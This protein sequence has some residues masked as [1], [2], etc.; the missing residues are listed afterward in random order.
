MIFHIRGKISLK[1]TKFVV[2]DA[3]GIGYK[4]SVTGDTLQKI[5]LEGKEVFLWTYL[6]VRENAMDLYGFFD[7]ES[8]DFFEL[9]ITS[10]SGI[11]PKTALSILNVATVETLRNAI[12]SGDTS[13]LTKVS[14]IGK[15]NAEKI[16][17]ELRDKIGKFEGQSTVS[18]EVD[19]VEALKSLGYSQN[20]AREALKKID[21][22]ISGTG[23]KVKAVLKI[24]GN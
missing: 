4:V 18:E 19:V 2:I 14:G 23:E 3:N 10:V 11:G 15:K 5:G 17:L 16:V 20:E 6:A 8:L 7:K 21:K 9:L 13:Y 12:S 24:L 22:K 1:E